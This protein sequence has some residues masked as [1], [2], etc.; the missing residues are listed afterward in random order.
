[1]GIHEVFV[2]FKIIWQIKYFVDWPCSSDLRCIIEVLILTCN[3]K[4]AAHPLQV[5]AQ[6]SP[7]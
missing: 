7:S 5:F 6:I 3:F 4:L 2:V 1:M